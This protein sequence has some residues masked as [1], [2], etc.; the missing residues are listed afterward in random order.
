MAL[1][2]PIIGLGRYRV[3]RLAVAHK[4]YALMLV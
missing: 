2:L 3:D 4:T 1:D